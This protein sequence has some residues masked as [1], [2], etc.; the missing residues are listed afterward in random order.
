MRASRVRR[1]NGKPTGGTRIGAGRDGDFKLPA[2]IGMPGA[3]RD[4][5]F[6]TKAAATIATWRAA[7][8]KA[9]AEPAT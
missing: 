9:T 5:D 2:A 7:T 4:P 8:A 1:A 6:E 3:W